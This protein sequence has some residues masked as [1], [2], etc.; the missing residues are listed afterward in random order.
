M[1][2]AGNI[3]SSRIAGRKYHNLNHLQDYLWLCSICRP[4][5]EEVYGKARIQKA[6]GQTEGELLGH[7]DSDAR[8]D[9]D[10]RVVIEVWVC[11]HHP[12]CKP[13]TN[14]HITAKEEWLH[15]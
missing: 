14:K 5:C 12:D 13:K 7:P 3:I 15:L 2:G 11:P 1:N 9:L 4:H 6:R 8:I 10:I